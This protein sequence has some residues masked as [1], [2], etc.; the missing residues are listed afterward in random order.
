MQNYDEEVDE[1]LYAFL[2]QTC[3]DGNIMLSPEEQEEFMNMMR[4]KIE[5]EDK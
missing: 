2:L 5:E 1:A 4:K 3:P